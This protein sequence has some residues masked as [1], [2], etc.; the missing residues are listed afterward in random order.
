MI[1]IFIGLFDF[2]MATILLFRWFK[3][4]TF[5]NFIAVPVIYFMG[6]VCIVLGILT[7]RNNN[8]YKNTHK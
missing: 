3:Y 4:S 2:I 5:S 6:I 7:I 1:S 8:V